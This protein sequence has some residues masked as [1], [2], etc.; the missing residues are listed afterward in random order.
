MKD[1]SQGLLGNGALA[2]NMVFLCPRIWEL[3]LG[4]V[5]L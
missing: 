2:N 4:S 3:G 1:F 5:T